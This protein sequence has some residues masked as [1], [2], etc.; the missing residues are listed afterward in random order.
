MPTPTKH[1]AAL[2]AVAIFLPALVARPDSEAWAASAGR[3][4]EHR[5][6]RPRTIAGFIAEQPRAAGAFVDSLG[7]N[8]HL[9]EQGT[10]YA[11]NFSTMAN[12]LASL[13]I[14]HVRDGMQTGQLQTCSQARQLAAEGV[15]FQYIT[16][17]SDRS[18][19]LISWAACAGNAVERFEAPNEYDITHPGDDSNWPATLNAFQR[20]LWATVKGTAALANVSVAGPA[21]IGASDYAAVGDLSAFE[22]VGNMHDYFEGRNPGT[23][24]WGSG[25]YGSIPYNLAEA[26]Y[27]SVSKPIESTETGYEIAPALGNSDVTEWVAAKYLPRLFLEQWNAGVPRT[28]LYEMYDEGSAPFDHYGLVRSDTLAPRWGYWALKNL[29]AVLQDSALSL[30]NAGPL[31]WSLSGQTWNVHHSILQKADGTLYLALWIEWPYND[32]NS[33]AVFSIPPQT[34]TV[35]MP[36]APNS[37]SIYSYDSRMN[38]NPMPISPSTQIHLTLTDSVTLLRMKW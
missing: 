3:A 11:A 32:P 18:A 7:V 36:A 33:G 34:V 31:Y 19:D 2:L 17:I 28:Y 25:G 20:S 38:L 29:V 35:T 8:V 37:A 5:F 4:A 16:V 13:G 30:G 10:P 23:P 26:A 27:G 22:D 24:G 12:Q 21:L 6:P 1:R 9:G 14:H 15:R